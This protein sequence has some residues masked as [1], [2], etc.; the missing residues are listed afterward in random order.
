MMWIL[1]LILAGVAGVLAYL[2]FKQRSAGQVVVVVPAAEPA[3]PSAQPAPSKHHFW[4][5]QFIVPDTTRACARALETNGHCFAYGKVPAVPLAGCDQAV[6]TCHLRDL[7]ERRSGR[8]RRSGHE[9]REDVRFE[10]KE[11]RRKGKDRRGDHY[12]WRFTA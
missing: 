7:E 12:D 2:L 1:V 10:D 5:K 4:G 6:C 8:E 3:M 9:R 11:D